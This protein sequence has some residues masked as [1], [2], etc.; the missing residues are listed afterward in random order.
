MIRRG[1]SRSFFPLFVISSLM[2]ML[3]FIATV[4]A[5]YTTTPPHSFNGSARQP[6]GAVPAGNVVSARTGDTEV[7]SYT[8][9]TAGLY[10]NDGY[11]GVAGWDD[12]ST[13]RFFVCNKDTGQTANYSA[14][15]ITALDLTISSNCIADVTPPPPPPG[16]AAGGGGAAAGAVR[17][18]VTEVTDPVT[19]AA[20]SETLP[21]DWT[22]IKV[23]QIGETQSAAVTATAASINDAI[24]G[25]TQS[26]A[27]SALE[28][29]KSKIDSGAWSRVAVTV[30]RE[31]FKVTNK[32]NGQQVDRTRFTI[33]ITVPSR[34]ENLQII[35]VILKNVAE[36]IDDVSFPDLV[37]TI[38]QRDPIV[39]WVVAS[40]NAG[41]TVS[42]SYIVNK[43]VNE[44][45]SSTTLAAGNVITEAGPPPPPPAEEEEEEEKKPFIPISLTGIIIILVIVGAG[46]GFYYA[47]R[48]VKA[49]KQQT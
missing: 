17:E 43:R 35:Q 19:I 46:L 4:Q 25:A 36:T 3:L 45:D 18:T 11:M 22:N 31:V 37:P 26:T 49:R 29:L 10:G 15:E 20:I 2:L 33:T 5:E 39:Q 30:T 38:L 23:D 41:E 14:G 28:E 1:L 27:V 21:A 47:F 40:L 6:S 32:D 13:I 44:I 48:R 9:G 8:M 42:F 34:I 12:N 7:G 24:S 16:A